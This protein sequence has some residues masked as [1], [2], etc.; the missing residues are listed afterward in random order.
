MKIIKFTVVPILLFMLA[1]IASRAFGV[2]NSYFDWIALLV[3][4]LYPLLLNDAR[5]VNRLFLVVS[6]L[7]NPLIMF[8]LAFYALAV[9]YGDGL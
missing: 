5:D 1:F 3:F 2:N 6:L 4:T 8:S 9:L 7:I